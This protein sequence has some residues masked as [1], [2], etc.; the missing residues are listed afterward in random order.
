MWE[1]DA[2]VQMEDRHIDVCRTLSSISDPYGK[3]GFLQVAQV[4]VASVWMH[5]TDSERLFAT[6]GDDDVQNTS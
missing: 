6:L 2:L 1:K 3:D 4:A 5:L